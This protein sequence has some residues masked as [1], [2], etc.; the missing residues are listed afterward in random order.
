[1]ESIMVHGPWSS[2]FRVL[3]NH[4]FSSLVPMGGLGDETTGLVPHIF[5]IVTPTL[6]KHNA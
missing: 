2:P 5:E 1:M 3:V 4:W 6:I